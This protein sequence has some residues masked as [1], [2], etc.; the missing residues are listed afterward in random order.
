MENRKQREILHCA[1]DHKLLQAQDDTFL[2][3]RAQRRPARKNTVPAFLILSPD[4]TVRGQAG[5]L[6]AL[7]LTLGRLVRQITRT[8]RAKRTYL[9]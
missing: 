6:T 9:W 2:P 8:S 5:E 4:K 7:V 3:F 1:H